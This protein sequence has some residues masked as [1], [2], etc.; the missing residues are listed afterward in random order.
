[1]MRRCAIFKH[2]SMTYALIGRTFIMRH[3]RV[4]RPC[5][6]SQRQ[7]MNG[8]RNDSE[9]PKRGFFLGHSCKGVNTV[10]WRTNLQRNVDP[11]WGARRLIPIAV[12][13]S[14]VVPCW[15][16][17]ATLILIETRLKNAR[18]CGVC[19]FVWIVGAYI[20]ETLARLCGL[21]RWVTRKPRSLQNNSVRFLVFFQL[22][23]LLT[24]FYPFS[25][26][27]WRLKMG[28]L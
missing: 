20:N 6:E 24:I 15:G 23:F 9:W 26:L 19:R 18:Y 8:V 5:Q 14:H 4:T 1:M 3:S 12:V 28:T 2:L 22:S 10:I 25:L 11:S 7:R 13:M 17:C 21:L 16:P 27:K